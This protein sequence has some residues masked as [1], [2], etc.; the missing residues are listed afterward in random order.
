MNYAQ[1]ILS[2]LAE[3]EHFSQIFL[4]AGAPPVEKDGQRFSIVINTVLTP[5]DISDTLAFFQSQAL[6]P[7]KA[8]TEKQG[9]L[10]VG[11]PNQGRFR[12]QYLIQRG[13]PFMVIR[14]MPFDPP[15][16]ETILAMSAQM[17]LIEEVL[18]LSAGRIIFFTGSSPD[19]LSRFVYAA[20]SR[21]NDSKNKVILVLDSELSYLMKHRNSIVI[22]VEVGTDVATLSDG[23]RNALTLAPDL[24]YV[25]NPRTPDE[26]VNLMCA[27]QAGAT[28]LASMVTISAH[29]LLADLEKRLQEDFPLLRHFIKQVIGVTTNHDGQIILTDGD[30]ASS[31]VI[32]EY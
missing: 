7:G 16:L 31:E 12:I 1:K 25:N 28:V 15:N 10:S 6:Q 4:I 30:A 8:M 20:L 26:F 32:S 11:I 17:S 13:S 9:I 19:S 22:Q 14:R 23:I 2:Y 5:E 18:T 21:M 29:H 3:S 27:A 24:I